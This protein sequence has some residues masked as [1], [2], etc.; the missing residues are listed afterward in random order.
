MLQI[1]EAFE[2]QLSSVNE[3]F[4]HSDITAGTLDAIIHI[5]AQKQFTM[6]QENANNQAWILVLIFGSGL[7]EYTSSDKVSFNWSS[8]CLSCSLLLL[9]FH[10]KKYFLEK[11]RKKRRIWFTLKEFCHARKITKCLMIIFLISLFSCDTK[12]SEVS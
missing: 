10:K 3:I 12:R 4:I 8:S 5:T 1:A 7:K 2:S 11:K 6:M 9:F